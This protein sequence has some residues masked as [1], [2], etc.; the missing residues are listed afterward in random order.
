MTMYALT[1]IDDRGRKTTIYTDKVK[2]GVTD[3]VMESFGRGLSQLEV[4]KPDGTKPFTELTKL[5]ALT[6]EEYQK[7]AAK[8]RGPKK[9]GSPKVGDTD[10]LADIIK[11][12]KSAADDLSRWHL[13]LKEIINLRPESVVRRL[14]VLHEKG[15]DPTVFV[16]NLLLVKYVWH[17]GIFVLDQRINPYDFYHEMREIYDPAKE[18]SQQMI[19]ALPE[20]SFIFDKDDWARL[21]KTWL[22]RR[23]ALKKELKQVQTDEPAKSEVE[24][25]L[26]AFKEQIEEEKEKEQTKGAVWTKEQKAIQRRLQNK[27][28]PK[29]KR[30]FFR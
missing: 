15:G 11:E 10:D 4:R 27:Q 8:K 24:D 2:P 20:L 23:D 22:K 14:K 29:K 28:K 13:S 30:G 18:W 16:T 6:E 25:A 19:E 5:E 7:H 1:F 12:A 21:R 3:K 26:A 17:S 9:K